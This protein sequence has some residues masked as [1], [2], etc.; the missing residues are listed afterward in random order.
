M[1]FL[2]HPS[3]AFFAVALV[4]DFVRKIAL[5]SFISQYASFSFGKSRNICPLLVYAPVAIASPS[6]FLHGSELLP[7]SLHC[8]A[9]WAQTLYSAALACGLGATLASL[10]TLLFPA[11]TIVLALLGELFQVFLE[12]CLLAVYILDSFPLVFHAQFLDPLPPRFMTWKQSRTTMA[13]GKAIL[14]IERMLSLRSMETS[15][16]AS[17]PFAASFSGL[18]Q[19]SRGRCP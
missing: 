18:W 7:R 10:L 6:C 16:T 3:S 15:P 5:R 2:Y 14:T 13:L 4:L 17:D 11:V 12:L 19:L 1:T 8:S 9:S